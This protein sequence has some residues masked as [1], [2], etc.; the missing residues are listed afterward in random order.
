[1]ARK[2]LAVA[3][4]AGKN[5]SIASSDSEQENLGVQLAVRLSCRVGLRRF[6]RN[7]THTGTTDRGDQ[8]V[9]ADGATAGVP[10]GRRWLCG[11]VLLVVE[12]GW[13]AG[14][15]GLRGR[16]RNPEALEDAPG[17]AHVHDRRD[18]PQAAMAFRAVQNIDVERAAQ[19]QRPRESWRR[20][21]EQAAEKARPMADAKGV[22]REKLRIPTIVITGIGPS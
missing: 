20:R 7:C 3:A 19:K 16:G 6:I 15:R 1:M 18:D 21:V 10:R 9:G 17:G 4:S 13:I 2:A 12:V 5:A 11:R 22:R 14:A 8:V